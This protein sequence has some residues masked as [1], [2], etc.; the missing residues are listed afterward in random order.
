MSN[1]VF[2]DLVRK[3]RASQSDLQEAYIA[4]IPQHVADSMAFEGEPV[5]LEFLKANLAT[6]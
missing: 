2:M 4:A 1:D 6:A 3:W 5:D